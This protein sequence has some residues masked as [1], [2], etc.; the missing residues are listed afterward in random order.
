MFVLRIYIHLLVYF[1]TMT[2][3]TLNYDT[4]N[5]A[6]MSLNPNPAIMTSLTHTMTSLTHTMT[7][8]VVADYGLEAD[9]FKVFITQFTPLP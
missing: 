5:Y 3:L 6:N 4:T 1:S 8:F 7:S 2:S 9:L